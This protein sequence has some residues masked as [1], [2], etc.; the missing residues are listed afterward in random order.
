MWFVGYLTELFQLLISARVRPKEA[1]I[2][3]LNTVSQHWSGET[4]GQDTNRVLWNTS[5]THRRSFE[6]DYEA[7]S[8]SLRT[9]RLERELQM[10]QI[11]VTRCSCITI[12]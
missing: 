2:A 8:K 7:I 9:G 5:Q 10:V 11:S 12:L 3:F 4:P 1:I 6:Y